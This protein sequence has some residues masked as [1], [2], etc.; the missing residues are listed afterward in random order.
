VAAAPLTIRGTARDVYS[1]D[2]TAANIEADGRIQVFEWK[3]LVTGGKPVENGELAGSTLTA[4][5]PTS[6]RVR[7]RLLVGDADCEV[8]VTIQ[9]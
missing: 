3:P 4:R 6:G 9:P 7:L 1:L 2:W 5:L 8:T